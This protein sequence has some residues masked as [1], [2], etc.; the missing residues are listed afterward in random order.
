[1]TEA[2]GEGQ[3]LGLGPSGRKIS[4]GVSADD[5]KNGKHY[6]GLGD[7]QPPGSSR[8]FGNEIRACHDF[9]S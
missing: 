3:R 9:L 7:I 6:R 1:M 8:E 4:L 2:F 5:Q